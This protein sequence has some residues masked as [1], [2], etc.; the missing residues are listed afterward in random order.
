MCLNIRG[1][2]KLHN[3]VFYKIISTNLFEPKVLWAKGVT[4]LTSIY[5]NCIVWK[6]V[7]SSNLKNFKRKLCIGYLVWQSCQGR[8][9][10]EVLRSVL[11]NAVLRMLTQNLRAAIYNFDSD[12]QIYRLYKYTALRENSIKCIE[13]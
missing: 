3:K 13:I 2:I 4:I 8:Y 6:T 12:I 5:L 1:L 11:K 10:D 9:I 7:L